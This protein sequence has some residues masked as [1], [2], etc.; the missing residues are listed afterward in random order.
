MGEQKRS[1]KSVGMKSVKEGQQKMVNGKQN[2]LVKQKESTQ[3]FITA[4]S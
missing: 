4:S 3:L 2:R 1:Y